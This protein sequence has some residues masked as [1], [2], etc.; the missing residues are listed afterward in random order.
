MGISRSQADAATI[1]ETHV[2]SALVEQV[3]VGDAGRFA[4]LFRRDGRFG[5]HRPHSE[6]L[7]RGI[8]IGEG[9][10]ARPLRVVEQRGL[11]AD[12]PARGELVIE[13]VKVMG[14]GP[15][16]AEHVHVVLVPIAPQELVW[17]R[18]RVPEQALEVAGA[19]RRYPDGQV[20]GVAGVAGHPPGGSKGPHG[21]H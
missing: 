21:E 18:S 13:H 5:R 17:W 7:A 2:V 3:A 14:A 11:L 4:V 10:R 9:G 20:D 1:G 8:E 16:Q 6:R 12:P 15:W 19:R